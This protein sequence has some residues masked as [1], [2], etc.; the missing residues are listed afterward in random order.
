MSFDAITH[1]FPTGFVLAGS[2]S[3]VYQ[4][5]SGTIPNILFGPSRL[6]VIKFL[7]LI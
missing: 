6:Y 4:P 5:E 3:A 2:D 1:P 7:Y